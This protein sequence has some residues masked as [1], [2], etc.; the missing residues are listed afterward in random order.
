MQQISSQVKLKKKQNELVLSKET[1]EKGDKAEGKKKSNPSL[2]ELA[3][4]IH[5]FQLLTKCHSYV[6][7]C[8]CVCVCVFLQ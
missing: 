2:I 4:P 5:P 6:C 3:K 8:V 7:V 1:E